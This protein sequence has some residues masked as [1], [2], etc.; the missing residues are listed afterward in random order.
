[1]TIFEK[2]QTVR[3]ELKKR[4]L[5]MTGRNKYAEYDYFELND[6]LTPLNELMSQY[7]MT[8]IPSFSKEVAKLTAINFEK[9]EETYTI[10]SPMGTAMLKGCHEV[11]NIGAVETYQRRYLYQAMFDIAESDA[12]NGTQ[13]KSENEPK[14]GH[15]NRNR[16]YV[17]NSDNSDRQ[18]DKTAQN[19][20]NATDKRIAVERAVATEQ[21]KKQISKAKRI[22]ELIIG[23]DITGEQITEW[24]ENNFGSPK[25]VN[26]LTDEEYKKL[27][28]AIERSIKSI[29]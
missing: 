22:A 28:S 29:G 19:P 20:D 16:D 24:I 6:F 3:V 14:N 11:Q 15:R 21:G 1:M 8:A 10:E 7:K 12:I 17:D 5:K 4:E 13:G 2:I 25:K 27:Y 9:P 26:D 23:T 18:T